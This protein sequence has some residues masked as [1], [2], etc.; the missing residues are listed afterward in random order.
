MKMLANEIFKQIK[1]TLVKGKVNLVKLE[2][3]DSPEIYAN[4]CK[5]LTDLGDVKVIARIDST[6]F[7]AFAE[8]QN[9]EWENSLDYLRDHG[10]VDNDNPLTMYRNEAVNESGTVLLLLMGADA[11]VDKGSIMDFKRI[12]IDDIIAKV[13]KDYSK[14]FEDFLSTVNADKDDCK[15]IIKNIFTSIFKNTN[16]DVIQLSRFVDHIN[17]SSITD[18]N[19]FLDEVF[20]TL[21]MWWNI[22]RIESDRKVA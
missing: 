12:S 2:D 16:V 1:N 4:V 15:V 19:D 9:N 14:W 3:F 11:A 8:K 20:G 6:K 18:I 7:Q 21:N 17:E 22:P 13:K 10:F 5:L